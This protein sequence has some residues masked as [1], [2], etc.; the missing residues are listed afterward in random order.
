MKKQ[1]FSIDSYDMLH[2]SIDGN[3]IGSDSK[4]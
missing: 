2:H 4:G 1:V 3:G